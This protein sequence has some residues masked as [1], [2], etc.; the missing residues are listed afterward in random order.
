MV[1]SLESTSIS[2]TARW[3]RLADQPASD[4]TFGVAEEVLNRSHG[5]ISTEKG[6]EDDCRP[7]MGAPNFRMFLNL[8]EPI[9]HQLRGTSDALAPTL[10]NHRRTYDTCGLGTLDELS[11]RPH[12]SALPLSL[13]RAARAGPGLS[14]TVAE[15]SVSCS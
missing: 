4:I 9:S 6:H 8:R 3:Q 11:R 14:T 12:E 7:I 2:T 13:I 10:Q 5:Q 15:N 1:S